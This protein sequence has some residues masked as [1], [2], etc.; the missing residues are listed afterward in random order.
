MLSI[1]QFLIQ[2]QL[3]PPTKHDGASPIPS[4]QPFP[5]AGVSTLPQL[6]GAGIPIG[7]HGHEYNSG[8]MS[9]MLSS[10]NL[11][12]TILGK[13]SPA[14]VPSSSM[15]QQ[16]QSQLAKQLHSHQ[17][18]PNYADVSFYTQ[19]G[20][21]THGFSLSLKILIKGLMQQIIIPQHLVLFQMQP[22]LKMICKT[23][24]IHAIK[25]LIG[26]DLIYNKQYF[27]IILSFCFWWHC[28][29]FNQC[30]DHSN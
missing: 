21:F 1:G 28:G 12:N 19:A 6:F 20:R 9:N 27:Y 29:P 7:V 4:Q 17:T 25:E 26:R 15:L 2:P 23:A 14:F 5:S 16:Q 30:C 13:E 11:S 24:I 10:M 3:V 18:L 22:Q 8:E